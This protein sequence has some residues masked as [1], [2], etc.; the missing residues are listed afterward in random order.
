VYSGATFSAGTYTLSES[1]PDG[2]IASTWVCVGGTQIGSQ[3][4][5]VLGESATCTIT[6]DDIAAVNIKIFLPIA[7][8]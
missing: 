2:Y 4:T 6:N 3:I 1:G 5:L 8:R 7:L